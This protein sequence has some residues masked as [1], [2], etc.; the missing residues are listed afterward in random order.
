MVRLDTNQDFH[1]ELLRR[2]LKNV[3]EDQIDL[4]LYYD[5]EAAL[6]IVSDFLENRSV[7]QRLN[8]MDNEVKN[9]AVK[10]QKS[11]NFN[12]YKSAAMKYMGM[13]VYAK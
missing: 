9:L 12:L 13:S 11:Q 2:T 7:G 4:F 3:S 5:T 8:K 1:F 6:Q 10:I